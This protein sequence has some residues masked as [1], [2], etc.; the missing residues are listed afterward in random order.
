[1]AE[2]P[3][4]IDEFLTFVQNKIDVLDELSIV[5]IC[6]TNFTDA[7]IETGK[8]VLVKSLPE[9]N[10]NITRKGEDKNK[11]NVKDVIKLLKESEPSLQPVFVARNL[12]RL[13]PVSFDSIDVTRLLKDMAGMKTELKNIRNDAATKAE[14]TNLQNKISSDLTNLRSTIIKMDKN[15]NK[16]QRSQNKDNSGT[17]TTPQRQLTKECTDKKTFNSPAPA[18]VRSRSRS[19][20]SIHIINTPSYRDIVMP[21]SQ[22]QTKL[23]PAVP[24]TKVEN[25]FSVVT[26][27]KRKIKSNMCGTATKPSKIQVAELTS[28]VYIS[29]LTKSTTIDNIKEHITDMGQECCDIHLLKQ[30][31]LTD[32]NSFRVVIPKSKLE[33]FL[34]NEFWPE[35]VKYRIFREYTPRS[36][37]RDLQN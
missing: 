2:T 30:Q 16:T 10:R 29:R 14:M 11:K 35:G 36:N 20:E 37:S 19:S 25:G 6:A 13:P 12:N 18:K 34:S 7:E 31:K 5:N 17:F 3:I 15:T 1:M 23:D 22:A 24:S 28:S 8:S 33:V 27:K 26:N 32:F 4:I 9:G 21:S